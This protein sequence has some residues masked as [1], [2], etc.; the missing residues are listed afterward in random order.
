MCDAGT[1]CLGVAVGIGFLVSRT[2]ACGWVV[3]QATIAEGFTR[4]VSSRLTDFE[5]QLAKEARS[6]F[7]SDDLGR[8]FAAL[9]NE[10]NLKA[11][12]SAWLWM[13]FSCYRLK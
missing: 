9:S 11:Q 12:P 4:T 13:L 3:S 1:I 7:D 5:C 8:Y 10:A 2:E 6:N